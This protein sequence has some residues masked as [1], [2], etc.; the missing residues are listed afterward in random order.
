MNQDCYV[1]VEDVVVGIGGGNARNLKLRPRASGT[2]WRKVSL[3]GEPYM[4]SQLEKGS[5]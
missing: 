4:V 3:E 2:T 5:Y 1:R